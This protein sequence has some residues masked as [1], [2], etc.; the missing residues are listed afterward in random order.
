MCWRVAPSFDSG[1]ADPNLVCV[2]GFDAF[3]LCFYDGY[4]GLVIS[5]FFAVIA[6]VSILIRDVTFLIGVVVLI[7]SVH[8]IFLYCCCYCCY[9]HFFASK[10]IRCSGIPLYLNFFPFIYNYYYYYYNDYY[11]PRYS[12][13]CLI[14]EGLATTVAMLA[15][16]GAI[17]CLRCSWC[18]RIR[19][20]GVVE[21]TMSSYSS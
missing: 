3:V 18:A 11:F 20:G 10:L 9:Y 14:A 2:A 13:Q 1:D 21:R 5:L 19:S 16:V 7:L 4:V 15:A 17:G 6:A 8:V 12:Y